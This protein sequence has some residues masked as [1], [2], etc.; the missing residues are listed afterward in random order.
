MVSEESSRTSPSWK[1]ASARVCTGE[2]REVG[3]GVGS[4]GREKRRDSEVRGREAGLGME[5][6]EQS[7]ESFLWRELWVDAGL[8]RRVAL[9]ALSG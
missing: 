4:I 2:R 9:L 6:L 1:R 3:C 7:S 5:S 8:V